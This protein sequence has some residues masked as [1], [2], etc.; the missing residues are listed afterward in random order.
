MFVLYIYILSYSIDFTLLFRFCQYYIYHQKRNICTCV[1]KPWFL[2]GLPWT[3][4]TSLRRLF[5]RFNTNFL[6][7]IRLLSILGLVSNSAKIIVAFV[8]YYSANEIRKCSLSH[9]QY[10]YSQRFFIVLST[11]D[12]FLGRSIYYV[13]VTLFLLQY[14]FNSL[15]INFILICLDVFRFGA[16]KQNNLLYLYSRQKYAAVS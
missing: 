2:Y 7:S 13:P 9:T 5:C 6:Y 12:L 16:E 4:V 11:L 3:L 10:I 8:F 14:L 15:S 1:N